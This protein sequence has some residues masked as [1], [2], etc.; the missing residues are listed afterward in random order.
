MQ[1]PYLLLAALCLLA[2]LA[3]G[4]CHR[5]SQAEQEETCEEYDF[6]VVGLGPGGAVIAN[7]L[8]ENGRWT[9]LGLDRGAPTSCTECDYTDNRPDIDFHGP[10]D[11]DL[12]TVPQEWA[13]K[14]VLA[15]PRFMGFGG[16]TE[17]F[18]FVAVRPDP[19]VLDAKWP[20]GWH[21][22][23]LAKYFKRVQSHYCHYLPTQQSRISPAECA[24]S[25]GRRGPVQINPPIFADINQVARDFLGECREQGFGVT[26]DY[27]DPDSV[28]GCAIL[29]Q[30]KYQEDQTD[31]TAPRVRGSARRYYLD[32][33]DA[34]ADRNNLALRNDS[35]VTSLIIEGQDN[36][37]A[38]VRYTRG[39]QEEFCARARKE[40]IVSGGALRTPH[41]LQLSGIGPSDVLARFD[42]PVKANN[43]HVG[44]HLQDQPAINIVVELKDTLPPTRNDRNVLHALL[45]S[46]AY[47][48]SDLQIFYAEAPNYNAFAPF[49]PLVRSVQE[50]GRPRQHPSAVPI[51]Y[52]LCHAARHRGHRG[53]PVVEPSHSPTHRL[54]I[55]AP[56]RPK[57]GRLHYPDPDHYHARPERVRAGR[58]GPGRSHGA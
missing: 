28:H 52:H 3:A 13:N 39:G 27:L 24:E 57:T 50:G 33:S 22:K 4:E 34:V 44:R 48:W 53:A 37:V 21:E 5:G 40:V 32:L 1:K 58:A 29:Q 6:I 8:S 7:R 46:G 43:E 42:I 51:V 2:L 26:K 9:V 12:F 20:D 23:D 18:G 16:T 30:F 47:P 17:H 31:N 10:W 45:E 36:R 25:H 11:D 55:P 56:G 15:L 41:L 54:R 38:G 19:G 49:R 35:L 14:R